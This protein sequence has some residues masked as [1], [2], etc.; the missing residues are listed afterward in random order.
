MLPIRY[1]K[2]QIGIAR[3]PPIPDGAS[4]V[5]MKLYEGTLALQPEYRRTAREICFM[6]CFSSMHFELLLL[7]ETMCCQF[8]NIDRDCFEQ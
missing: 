3:Q 8:W 6:V 4:G 1:I 7:V 2:L 5:L